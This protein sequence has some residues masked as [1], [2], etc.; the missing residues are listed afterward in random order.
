[1]IENVTE[2]DVFWKKNYDSRNYSYRFNYDV[3]SSQITAVL[4]F[5]LCL[6]H[7]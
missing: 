3:T 4:F 7:V 6:F 1:M 2:I 5:S